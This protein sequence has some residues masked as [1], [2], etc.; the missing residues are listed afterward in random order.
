MVAVTSNIVVLLVKTSC[1]D[2]VVTGIIVMTAVDPIFSSE[3]VVAVELSGESVV[4]ASG[5]K[6]IK[7]MLTSS[8]KKTCLYRR[9][10]LKNHNPYI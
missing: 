10:S 8:R 1:I 3:V 5:N 4:C 7:R 6:G 9:I 2:C